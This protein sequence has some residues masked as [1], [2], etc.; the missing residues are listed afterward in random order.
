MSRGVGKDGKDYG[1]AAL[2]WSPRQE[3][4]PRQETAL[5]KRALRRD[6]L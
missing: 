3:G 2:P 1:I 6:R 4:E 5:S